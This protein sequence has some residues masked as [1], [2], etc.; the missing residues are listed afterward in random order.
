MKCT[1]GVEYQKKN[2]SEK[3]WTILTIFCVFYILSSNRFRFNDVSCCV[4]FSS[5]ET[6][7]PSLPCLHLE[8]CHPLD[9]LRN[10]PSMPICL[11]T[12]E[13]GTFSFFPR[14]VVYISNRSRSHAWVVAFVEATDAWFTDKL[15]TENFCN[16]FF[17]TGIRK[18]VFIGKGDNEGSSWKFKLQRGKTYLR[19]FFLSQS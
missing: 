5:V 4:D 8:L 17:L 1:A 12:I 15:T 10:P 7:S 9:R 14:F 6:F 16:K 18:Q 19:V 13:V 3:S 11:V 2:F